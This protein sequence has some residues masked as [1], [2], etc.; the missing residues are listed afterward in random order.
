MQSDGV[1][2]DCNHCMWSGGGTFLGIARVYIDPKC[3][4]DLISSVDVAPSLVCP[5]VTAKLHASDEVDCIPGKSRRAGS[6]T[7]RGG[8]GFSSGGRGGGGGGGSGGRGLLAPDCNGALHRL[9]SKHRCVSRFPDSSISWLFSRMQCSLYVGGGCHVEKNVF[10]CI[11]ILWCT[12]QS[13]V[14]AETLHSRL[15]QPLYV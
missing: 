13:C 10:V 11:V 14:A 8:G 2:S 1:V 7:S 9:A 3:K 12:Y 5:D 15:R 6:G 4:S